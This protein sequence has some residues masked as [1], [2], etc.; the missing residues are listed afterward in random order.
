MKRRS[1]E[2]HKKVECCA[3]A[4]VRCAFW[5]FFSDIGEKR[6]IS[7]LSY[8]HYMCLENITVLFSLCILESC[9]F[10]IY[11]F[12]HGG[13]LRRNKKINQLHQFWSSVKDAK[14]KVVTWENIKSWICILLY[15][16]LS[17]LKRG[18]VRESC[19]TKGCEFSTRVSWD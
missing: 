6:H 4:V 3:S 7:H 9:V 13:S 5:R 19:T 10:R 16:L 8:N 11:I 1:T 15:F 18:I 17:W 12:F 2:S 14:I